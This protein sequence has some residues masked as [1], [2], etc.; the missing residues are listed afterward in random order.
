M[1]SNAVSKARAAEVLTSHLRHTSAHVT[2]T[3]VM[4]SMGGPLLIVV[5]LLSKGRQIPMQLVKRV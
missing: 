3:N 2:S 4:L 1:T 5:A